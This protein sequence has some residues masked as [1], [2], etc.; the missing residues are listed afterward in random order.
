MLNTNM[1]NKVMFV[2]RW[3]EQW[4]SGKEVKRAQKGHQKLHGD[5]L[6]C[7]RPEVYSSYGT[8]KPKYVCKDGIERRFINHNNFLE[9]G[10]NINL[11]L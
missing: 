4:D 11:L 3:T 5:K 7:S 8:E 6:N 9:D 2:L 1:L 10:V